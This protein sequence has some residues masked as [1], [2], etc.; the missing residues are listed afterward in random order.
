MLL[1]WFSGERTLP[2]QGRPA[3]CLAWHFFDP[4]R[5]A[6]EGRQRSRPCARNRM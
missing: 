5:L 2:A 3:G 1:A 4:K 6:S